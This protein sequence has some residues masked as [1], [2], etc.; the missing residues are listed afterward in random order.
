LTIDRLE[1]EATRRDQ[2]YRDLESRLLLVDTTKDNSLLLRELNEKDGKVMDL[3]RKLEDA[4]REMELRAKE[5]TTLLEQAKK[6]EAD[7]EGLRDRMDELNAGSSSRML[8]PSSSLLPSNA[9]LPLDPPVT[10]VS[11]RN[12]SFAPATGPN[13]FNPPKSPASTSSLLPSEPATPTPNS[14]FPGNVNPPH[15]HASS[16]AKL[17]AEFRQLQQVHSDTLSELERVTTSYRD[18][19]KEIADLADQVQEAKLLSDESTDG[20]P[21]HSSS[22]DEDASTTSSSYNSSAPLSLSG[23]RSPT[24]ILLS[25]TSPNRRRIDRKRDSMPVSSDFRQGGGKELR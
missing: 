3:E 8:H 15:D 12:E 9:S 6:S 1:R 13:A 23:N 17:D 20:V 16:D 18:A 21:S 11:D 14:S 19:L 10:G 5:R 7:R 25:P 22:A 2:A 24:A 4:M